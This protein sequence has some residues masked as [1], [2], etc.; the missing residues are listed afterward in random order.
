MRDN[1]AVGV[2][3]RAAIGALVSTAL[4]GCAQPDV[5]RLPG[6]VV[7]KAGASPMVPGV[8]WEQA[9]STGWEP[10]Q[11]VWRTGNRFYRELDG[12]A[13]LETSRNYLSRDRFL[14]SGDGR[15]N[16]KVDRAEYSGVQRLEFGREYWVAFSVNVHEANPL[17]WFLLNQFHDVKA[18]DDAVIPP[19]F[20]MMLV[21]NTSG[22]EV[23]AR[24][25][26]PG[27]RRDYEESVVYTVRDFPRKQ[28]HHFVYAL[29]FTRG[30]GGMVRIWH[31]GTK[32]VDDAVGLGFGDK[33]GPY[34]K[35][36]A[37]RD[38]TPGDVHVEYA[39]VE[40]SA[41]SLEKR[42]DA[43]LGLRPRLLLD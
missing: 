37:Y 14:L 18:E 22:L 5:S 21:P 31:N 35:Y 19:P 16:G 40:M 38:P 26:R 33:V 20:A 27:R 34:L 13:T 7:D 10:H 8:T 12:R 17:S 11:A 9:G 4:A 2:S 24:S 41:E 15:P 23:F 29:T 28:W 39:N 25:A 1:Y 36:G 3:R 43:P 32:V 6:A 42:V 30:T